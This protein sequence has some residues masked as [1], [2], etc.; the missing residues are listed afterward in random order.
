VP[1]CFTQTRVVGVVPLYGVP[2]GV[3]PLKAFSAVTTAVFITANEITDGT[4]SRDFLF[5]FQKH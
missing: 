3:V 1:F 5:D 2:L 4:L